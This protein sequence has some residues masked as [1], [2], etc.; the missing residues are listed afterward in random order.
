MVLLGLLSITIVITLLMFSI[1]M[2]NIFM[3]TR[4]YSFPHQGIMFFFNL[5]STI[6]NIQIY[7]LNMLNFFAIVFHYIDSICVSFHTNLSLDT[8]QFRSYKERYYS[9]FQLNLI[10]RV[11]FNAIHFIVEVSCINYLHVFS[12][13]WTISQHFNL[14]RTMSSH[15]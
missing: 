13:P 1:C 4:M 5:H 11:F 7:L 2:H 10:F 12:S 6:H 8:N 15:I 14:G 9:L 3:M